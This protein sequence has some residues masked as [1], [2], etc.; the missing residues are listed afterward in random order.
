MMKTKMK[1]KDH[2]WCQAIHKEELQA[3]IETMSGAVFIASILTAALKCPG[4]KSGERVSLCESL[5]LESLSFSL[6]KAN[7]KGS[8]CGLDE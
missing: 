6:C 3:A 2:V 7:V 8:A 5:T 4:V 1:R